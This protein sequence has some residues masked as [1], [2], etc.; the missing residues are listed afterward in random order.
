MKK[1]CERPSLREAKTVSPA[2]I[3]AVTKKPRFYSEA[4]K[5]FLSKEII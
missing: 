5:Y 3:I 1:K 2:S 4:F